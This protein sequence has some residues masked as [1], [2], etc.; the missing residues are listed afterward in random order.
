MNFIVDMDSIIIPLLPMETSALTHPVLLIEFTGNKGTFLRWLA[1]VRGL[2]L[3]LEQFLLLKEKSNELEGL[4]CTPEPVD[5]YSCLLTC[6]S[7]HHFFAT[8]FWNPVESGLWL[9]KLKIVKLYCKVLQLWL[10]WGLYIFMVLKRNILVLWILR[11]G[12][13]IWQ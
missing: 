13:I 11:D 10:N 12:H 7:F 1:E 5:S 8:A 9:I 3:F 4:K 2:S 6:D